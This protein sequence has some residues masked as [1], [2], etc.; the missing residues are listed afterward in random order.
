MILAGDVGG[1][2]VRLALFE[3]ERGK[4]VRKDE[5]TFRSRDVSGLEQPVEEFLAGRR[6]A[7]SGIGVAGPVRNGRCEATNLPWVVDA[8]VL[9]KSLALPR[10]ALVNDLFANALGL[11]ELGPADFAV[12]NA[13]IEDPEGNAALISAGT[14]LGEA[15]LVRVSGRFVP[16]ASEGGHASF[17]PRNP[18]EIDLLGHLQRTYS[19]VSFERVL[20]G[21][22]LAALYA[23]ERGGSD[24]RE[25]AW[26]SEEIAASGDAS[27]A[28]TA[29]ALAGKDAVAARVLEHF[30]AIYGGEAGN[31]ALK[32]LATGGVFV[33][34]GIAPKILP[35]LLDGTFFGAFCDKGRFAALL[36]K[37]P[38][39][40]VTNDHCALL[41]AARAGAEA[42]PDPQ[43]RR[44]G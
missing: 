44:D 16:Q 1:T 4:L 40:V 43:R 2:N 14:G 38:V 17:A 7:A 5:K 20:S 6:V 3:V 18:F 37:I 26:L 41:G 19:H 12:V 28:V 42:A 36:A 22:G 27:P 21:P 29:A 35:K 31:L 10:V 39:R 13:G 24:E 25:P 11:G 34:G 8:A 32:V 9:A 15:Y 33:G 23:F 30:V